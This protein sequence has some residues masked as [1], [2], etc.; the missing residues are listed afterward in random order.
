[1][2]EDFCRFCP[3]KK[4]LKFF[5]YTKTELLDKSET[6]EQK[7][8]FRKITSLKSKLTSFASMGAFN[9]NLF[10]VAKTYIT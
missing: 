1:M 2:Y 10:V 6:A 4:Y 7:Y 3:R 5:K 9:E 8:T